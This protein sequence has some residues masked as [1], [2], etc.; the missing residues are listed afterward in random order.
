ME[1]TILDYLRYLK[2][3]VSNS[4][5]EK[6][7]ASHPD[8]PSLLSVADT[9]DRLGIDHQIA[10]VSRENLG[11]IPFPYI[12]HFDNHAGELEII[13]NQNDL[14]ARGAGLD[15]WSGVIV[16]VEPTDIIADEENQKQLIADKFLN[17]TITVFL[18][19]VGALVFLPAFQITSWLYALLL[20]SAFG[21]AIVG[22]LLIAKEVGITYQAVETFC[23]TGTRSNCDKI[24]RSEGARLFGRISFSDTVLVYFAFQ[25]IALGFMIPL[26]ETAATIFLALA[27]VSLITIPVIIHSIYYQG[28]KAKAWCRLCLIVDG[29]L[30]VQIVLFALMY[31][32]GLI[33]PVLVDVFSLALTGAMLLAIGAAVL[34]AK[35]LTERTNDSNSAEVK[36]NRIKHDP[37]V[38][39]YK[40]DQSRRVDTTAFDHGMLIG[41]REAPIQLIMAANL[42]CHPCK[43]G[44]EKACQLV[45][46]YP[47]KVSLSIRLIR[48]GRGNIQMPSPSR[49]LLAWWFHHIH[50]KRDESDRTKELISCW[51]GTMN[52]ADLMEKYPLKS[53]LE[54]QEVEDLE[55]WHTDWIDQ[56]SI[57]RTPA[58][59][60]NGYE[61]PANYS[62]TD[63]MTIVAGLSEKITFNEKTKGEKSVIK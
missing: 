46:A 44:F 2:L 59:F 30:M 32:K 10:R 63:L 34:L 1:A 3:S 48:S 5:C 19:A 54:D 62:I 24:L 14:N 43:L 55:V 36:A 26:L 50:G 25:L 38:F 27:M 41:N 61:L 53:G 8:Y 9:L 4:Y 11:Q 28:V 16:R 49:Y 20:V 29:V 22:Y 33:Q 51:Y 15:H 39:L 35:Q 17:S 12:L 40:L 52:I 37:D 56:E 18:G 57:V 21:G 7:I 45:A 42:A 60:V 23:N 47:E 13:K 6:L 58:W 31:S